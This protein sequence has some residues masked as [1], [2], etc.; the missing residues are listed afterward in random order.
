M[1]Y[2]YFRNSILFDLSIKDIILQSSGDYV[3][4]LGIIFNLSFNFQIKIKKATRKILKLLGFI[5]K[6][7]AE[8]K[9]SSF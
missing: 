7:S 5:G 1:S 8:S 2:I 9:L 3:M 4:D 6:I